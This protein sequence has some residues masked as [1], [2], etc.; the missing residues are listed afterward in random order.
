MSRV[1][2]PTSAGGAR[3][4]REHR[5]VVRRDILVAG[6]ERDGAREQRRG[7]EHKR[8]QHRAVCRVGSGLEPHRS[9]VTGGCRPLL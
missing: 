5:A 2:T 7:L 4:D 1:A 9:S 8:K 3:E 6:R